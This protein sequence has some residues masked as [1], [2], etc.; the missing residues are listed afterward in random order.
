MFIGLTML[1]ASVQD[2]QA[3]K[4]TKQQNTGNKTF[5]KILEKYRKNP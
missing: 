2:G 5:N 1:H 4:K 3:K